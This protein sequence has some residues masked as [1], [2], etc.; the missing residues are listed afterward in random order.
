MTLPRKGKGFVRVILYVERFSQVC[1]VIKGGGWVDRIFALFLDNS[2]KSFIERFSRCF[3]S[4]NAIVQGR[5]RKVI[6]LERIL[7]WDRNDCS[8]R[9]FKPEPWQLPWLPRRVGQGHAQASSLV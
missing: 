4:I 9:W 2:E 6:M 5:C 3:V 7:Y 8:V 1:Q